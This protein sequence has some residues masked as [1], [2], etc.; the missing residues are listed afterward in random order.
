MEEE[1]DLILAHFIV[2]LNRILT[3]HLEE[4]V[5]V[6]WEWVWEVAFG[7]ST[8]AGRV[9][10]ESYRAFVRDFLDNHWMSDDR[11]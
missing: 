6:L 5:V 8:G 3:T 10:R 7:N 1:E 11:E 9:R 2:N 4:E